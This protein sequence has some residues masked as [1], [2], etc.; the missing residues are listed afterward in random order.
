MQV[1]RLDT[2]PH[3]HTP[4]ECVQSLL[5]PALTISCSPAPRHLWPF[6]VLSGLDSS[7][8]DSVLRM[9]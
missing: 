6:P 9:G 3:N 8:L 7:V 5:T 1:L 2:H 4:P